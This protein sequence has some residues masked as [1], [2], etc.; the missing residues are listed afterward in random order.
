MRP[1]STFVCS[2]LSFSIC[3][4]PG[5]T[6]IFTLAVALTTVIVMP[7]PDLAEDHSSMTGSAYFH[8]CICGNIFLS[9]SA[10]RNHQNACSLGKQNLTDVLVNLRLARA[11]QESEREVQ[12]QAQQEDNDRDSSTNPGVAGSEIPQSSMLVR[13]SNQINLLVTILICIL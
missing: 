9:P 8:R 6:F 4:C 10:F 5:R 1:P 12:A 7:L 13:G 3:H 11:R 2:V